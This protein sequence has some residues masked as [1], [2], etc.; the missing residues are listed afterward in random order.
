[1]NYGQSCHRPI[2]YRE[3]MRACRQATADGFTCPRCGQHHQLQAIGRWALILVPLLGA[4]VVQ[5]AVDPARQLAWPWPL[6][7]GL[8]FGFGA[9]CVLVAPC[10]VRFRRVPEATPST[11]S[12]EEV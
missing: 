1:M 4:M 9:F 12:A 2:S 3:T 8:A 5:E 10:F 7:V 11:P 6:M